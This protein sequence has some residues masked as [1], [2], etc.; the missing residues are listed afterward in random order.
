MGRS[1][2]AAISSQQS[3]HNVM[4]EDYVMEVRFYFCF[5]AVRGDVLVLV[6]SLQVAKSLTSPNPLIREQTLK[7]ML[8]LAPKLSSRTLST[9]LLKQ[10]DKLQVR[11]LDVLFNGLLR[12][13]QIVTSMIL[14]VHALRTKNVL[15]DSSPQ[16]AARVFL[17]GR[18]VVCL[19]LVSCCVRF[20]DCAM[21]WT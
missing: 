2:S 3:A 6:S 15:P 8:P 7:A 9:T 17:A 4:I 20:V 12:A 5:E 1:V 18:S 11:L 21:L 13:A 16:H 19:L 10:L 14:P